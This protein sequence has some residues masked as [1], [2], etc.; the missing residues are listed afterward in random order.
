MIQP[1]S[2]NQTWQRHTQPRCLQSFPH[3]VYLPQMRLSKPGIVKLI[4]S[5]LTSCVPDYFVISSGFVLTQTQNRCNRDG[6]IVVDHHT[7]E[8][9]NGIP[10]SLVSSRHRNIT[11]GLCCISMLP[12]VPI[13]THPNHPHQ[14]CSLPCF[15]GSYM[16]RAS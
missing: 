6:D 1:R 2:G 3:K 12:I 8:C 11:F 4:E 7:L 15:D 10:L 9:P 14:L 13:C 5:K 16:S